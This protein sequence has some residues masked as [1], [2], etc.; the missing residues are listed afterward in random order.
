MNSFELCFWLYLIFF[1]EMLLQTLFFQ[2]LWG[3][4]QRY[5]VRWKKRFLFD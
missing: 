2:E 5:P 3:F 4:F 1:S